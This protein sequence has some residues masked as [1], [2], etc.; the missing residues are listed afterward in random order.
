[1]T[2]LLSPRQ[3]AFCRF[4]VITGNAAESARRAGYSE[5]S[6]RQTAH[7]NL[8]KPY[9]LQRISELRAIA[10]DTR[11]REVALLLA[12]LEK[13]L[14]QAEAAG[15][16][17]AVVRIVALQAQLTGLTGKQPELAGIDMAERPGAPGPL[18]RIA[19]ACAALARPT[20]APAGARPP[21][22][23]D[24]LSDRHPDPLDR[25]A[26]EDAIEAPHPQVI[27][28]LLPPDAG[29]IDC[30]ETPPSADPA[31]A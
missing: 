25:L 3:E 13:A 22:I 20:Q 14:R 30:E 29:S 27:G 28:S 12:P 18:E 15:D 4:Y 11:R 8:T 16:Y 5:N 9:I 7:E 17:R 21:D 2:T 19:A 1:M 23:R 24:Y 31:H 10:E 26:L 6:A